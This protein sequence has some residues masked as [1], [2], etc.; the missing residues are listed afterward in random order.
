MLDWKL[1]HGPFSEWPVL[2]Q[3][4]KQAMFAWRAMY[5][6]VYMHSLGASHFIS[7]SMGMS[8]LE[9]KTL[10]SIAV[11]IWDKNPLSLFKA[12]LG[13]EPWTPL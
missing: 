10:K 3:W 9:T 6:L 4:R 1:N 13:I 5:V 8:R 7:T 11:T 2:Y 12:C